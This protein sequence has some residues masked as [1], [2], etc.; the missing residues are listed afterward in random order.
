MKIKNKVIDLTFFL[1]RKTAKPV[2]KTFWIKEVTGLEN[3]PSKGPAILVFN[4]QS[5]FD[6]LCFLSISPRNTFFLTAEKFF[7]S[8]LW[9]PLMVL[10]G[11]IKVERLVRDKRNVHSKVSEY[12]KQGRMIGIFPE[13]TRSGDRENLAKG[14]PGA[15]K[16]AHKENVP[17]I[18]I[19]IIGTFDIMSR[20]DSRPSFKKI[21]Q[22]NIGKPMDFNRFN[23]HK[24]NYREFMLLT[25]FVMLEI[26]KLSQKNT[27]MNLNS[28]TNSF[29]IAVFDL[30]GTIIR[31]QSQFLF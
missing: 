7:K 13:G 29:N 4:H 18:P 26:S 8:K 23:T 21:V 22:I 31:G 12:L 16:Y 11:Q 15:V 6:F 3:I 19:G 17:L 14:F 27:R 5:Y 2:F 1:I 25:H 24:L 30:D 28:K 20:N 9:K 10:T